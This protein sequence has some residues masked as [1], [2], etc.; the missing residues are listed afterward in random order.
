MSKEINYKISLDADVSG[1]VQAQKALNGVAQAGTAA[2]QVMSGNVAGAFV[3]AKNAFNALKVAFLANPFTAALMVLTSI[4]GVVAGTMWGNY[5]KGIE[6]SKKAIE[7]LIEKQ[8]QLRGLDRPLV[9]RARD[10]AESLSKSGN[11]EALKRQAAK[12]RELSD[13]QAQKASQ[14]AERAEVFNSNKGRG[15]NQAMVLEAREQAEILRTSAIEMDVIADLYEKAAQ[16]TSERLDR[17][18]KEAADLAAAKA[19]RDKLDQRNREDTVS[20]AERESDLR[21]S[22]IGKSPE[23]QIRLKMADAERRYAIASERMRREDTGLDEVAEYTANLERITAEI[24]ELNGQLEEIADERQKQLASVEKQEAEYDFSK[25]TPDKQLSA[26]A[27]RMKEIMG[28]PGWE[29]DAA[30][31]AEML[32]LRKRRDDIE[33]AKIKSEEKK[34]DPPG[35]SESSAEIKDLFDAY[36]AARA[37]GD[38]VIRMRGSRAGGFIDDDSVRRMTGSLA[39]GFSDR[40][41]PSAFARSAAELEAKRRGMAEAGKQLVETTGDEQPVEIKGEAIN[42]LRVI[43]GAL[44]KEA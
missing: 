25:L 17:E 40:L 13:Q 37:R 32:D 18:R 22:L 43:A 29:M 24:A 34:K 8:R 39:G 16:S 26:I 10:E 28:K 15:S 1:G 6:D 27:A 36:Y 35:L 9:E 14:Y 41:R 4:A 44:G 19:L 30:T 23:E 5:R 11:V 33:D 42:Y 21:R 3:S 12:A 2:A 7:G 20:D 31:R 38:D